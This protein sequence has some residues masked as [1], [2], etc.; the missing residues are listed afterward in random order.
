MTSTT[1]R[2]RASSSFGS[3]D[4]LPTGKYRARY[5]GPD[6]VRYSAPH[7]FIKKGDATAYLAQQRADISRDNWA[8]PVVAATTPATTV[9]FGE[10]AARTITLRNLAPRTIEHY[11]KILASH[12]SVFDQRTLSSITTK[13]V[14]D[15]YSGL[16]VGP[17][18][19]AHSY[20]LL[21]TILKEAERKELIARNPCTI[22]RAGS[23]KRVIKIVPATTDEL[24]VITA[25]M[26]PRLQAIVV[27]A[28][29]CGLRF[30]ELVGLRR[31]DVD[32]DG[33]TV[34]VNRGVVRVRTKLLAGP[35]KSAASVRDVAVPPH[36][37]HI[38]RN[39]LI[40]HTGPSEFALLFPSD[41]GA[42]Y[43][44][45]SSLY[46]Y[47]HPA[48]AAAGRDDLRF[49]DLRHT[50]ALFASDNG[51]SIPEMMARLGHSTQ[52]ASMKYW[53]VSQGSDVKLAARISATATGTTGPTVEEQLAAALAEIERLKHAVQPVARHPRAGTSLR[54]VR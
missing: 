34:R 4:L 46:R 38:V 48:R 18:M 40:E 3:V 31:A 23:S 32:P 14:E 30:G 39:H 16:D 52:G 35:T 51:A 42:T 15:W 50:G 43:L 36:V 27:I 45:S 33:L 2:R 53:H 6:G 11:E 10:F 49:H 26:P 37:A 13:M 25:A 20:S 19:K 47:Y 24:T 29:W 54:A 28:A 7:T 44:S 12:L 21:R 1:T 9:Q 5:Y 17:T 8:P 22:P 41:T